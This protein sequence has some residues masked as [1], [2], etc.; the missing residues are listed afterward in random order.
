MCNNIE[1]DKVNEDAINKEKVRPVLT[2]GIPTYNRA[3]FLRKCI[4]NIYSQVG[5]DSRFEVLVCDNNSEDN[6][7]TVIEELRKNYETLVYYKNDT[8]IGVSKN[9]QKVLELSKGEYINLHGDDDYFNEGVYNTIINMINSN[10][11]C[12]LMYLSMKCHPLITIRGIG[13]SNY[14]TDSGTGGWISGMVINNDAY[15]K[16]LNKE[17]FL[18]SSLNHIYIQLELLRFN[19]N[20]CILSGQINRVDTGSAGAYGYN[21]MEV[22]VQ[23]YLD[24]L[25]SFRNNGLTDQEI[26]YHKLSSL[27]ITFPLVRWIL[28][29][30]L[31][32]SVDGGIEIFTKYYKGEPYFDSKLEELKAILALK[33]Y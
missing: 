33:V 17:K 16:I 10:R 19:P 23:N 9:I 2:I 21:I 26:E 32:L 7:S 31:P 18:Y 29:T 24:I 8:N 22:A 5:N 6:T 25:Y 28:Q 4:E 11:D 14:Q 30:R 3:E 20:Y 13:M 12:D 1:E 15:K 27:A